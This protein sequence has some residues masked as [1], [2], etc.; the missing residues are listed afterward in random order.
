MIGHEDS[1]SLERLDHIFAIGDC[2]ETGA[3]QAGHT[4][5]YQGEV[6]VRNILSLIEQ[7]EGRIK[8]AELERYKPG[9]PSIKVSLGLVC[10]HYLGTCS[11]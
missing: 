2:A 3:I 4:A 7:R 11:D 9:A 8:K 10:H 1:H 5:Y 6:A